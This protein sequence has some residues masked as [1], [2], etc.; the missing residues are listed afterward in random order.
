VDQRD[1]C[2]SWWRRGLCGP[3]LVETGI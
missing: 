3:Y 1:N 2:W